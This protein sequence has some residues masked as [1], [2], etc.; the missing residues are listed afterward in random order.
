MD[1]KEA[2]HYA[3]TGNALL[4]CGSGFSVGATAINGQC[5][6]VG[7]GLCNILKKELNI[8]DEEDDDI[9]YY[10]TK[11]REKYGDSKLIEVLKS[12]FTIKSYER[13]HEIVS[14]VDWR[15]IYTTNYD[16]IIESSGKDYKRKAVTLS[17]EPRE[18]ENHKEIV[19]HLNGSIHNLT[20]E[21]L[22]SE[23]KL[24]MC[25]Y[26]STEFIESDWYEIFKNDI[27]SVKAIFFIGFSLKYD[28]DIRRAITSRKGIR[29]KCFF[30]D[31]MYMN[32]KNE[33]ILNNYGTVLKIG[34]NGFAEKIEK[35]SADFVKPQGYK[36]PLYV[37]EEFDKEEPKYRKIRDEDVINLLCRG[38]YLQELAFHNNSNDK[39]I[40]RR[41]VIEKVVD[42]IEE[43][44]KFIILESDFGNG[45]TCVLKVLQCELSKIGHVFNLVNSD[46][47]INSDI[48]NILVSYK[49]KKF[50][51]ID[52]YHNHF[53]VL[54]IMDKYNLLDC[55]IILSERSY[56]ND[57]LYSDVIS[58]S[59]ANEMNTSI[60]SLNK[61]T[62]SEIDSIIKLFNNYNLWGKNS[63]WPNSKKKKYI[64]KTCKRSLKD[65]LIGVF[66]APII[67][68]KLQ[69]ILDIIKSD[70]KAERII[71]M[72]VIAKLVNLELNIDDYLY[73]LSMTEL[74]LKIQKDSTIN[75]LI[76]INENNIKIK[77]SIL[78]HLII[79]NSNFSDKIVDILI[80]IMNRLDKKSN[81]QRYINVQFA[82]IS[83]SN[84][85]LLI[86]EKGSKFN[87]LIIRY[88]ESIKNTKYCNNNVFF[89]IQYANARISLKQFVEAKLCLDKAKA[90]MHEDRYYPQYDTCYSRYLLEN[91][92]HFKIKDG[93]YEVFEQAHNGIYN[94]K[95]TKDRWHFPLK[96]TNL[97]YE[98]FRMFYMTFSET[99][100]SLFIMQCKEVLDKINDYIEARNEIDGKTHP[101]V[102]LAKKHIEYI[103]ENY[104][105]YNEVAST[106]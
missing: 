31:S 56:I 98:Y 105:S 93:A 43:D 76:D 77:S 94:N 34:T 80:Y 82:L 71:I 92:L 30:I 38:E 63:K 65:V 79:K 27:D 64:K 87:N 20:S 51:F 57:T 11:F 24:T 102:L 41:D 16:N 39:Y 81:T 54:N 12:Y 104:I 45:K 22:D 106:K 46:E 4:F 52:N 25:S 103:L 91:Q 8:L 32:Q 15:R 89:W 3:I 18:N 101:R 14:N 35:I 68:D 48:D 5:L 17:S 55:V 42:I 26:S 44:K 100:K 62:N 95:N 7:S 40:F 59:Q 2:I 21:K 23:F 19:V 61:L 47:D 90:E 88:Y 6:P 85:Q 99:E 74:S 86:K 49:G 84:I 36:E 13:Y 66:D 69:E 9:E 75:E 60:I 67:R 29:E 83:F 97:Y 96:Q 28:L 53:K 73:F 50:F 58:L 72:S 78:A 37:F 70:K 33:D 10:S 1:L